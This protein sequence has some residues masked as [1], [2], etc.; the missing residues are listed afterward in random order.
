MNSESE[1]S[2]ESRIAAEVYGDGGGGFSA[3]VEL[4]GADLALAALEDRNLAI[5]VIE[6]ICGNLA[7]M[8]SRK[9][10]L[11]LAAHP[12][13]PRRIVLRLVREL[14]TF[15]LM[16]F[17]LLPAVAADL[18]RVAEELLVGRLSSV[19]LG[20]RVSLAR[21]SSARVAAALLLD[22]E[23]RVWQTALENPRLAESAVVAA[24]LRPGG[25]PAFVNAV[26]HHSKWSLRPEIRVA[27][28]R[29]EYTPLTRALEFARRLPPAV[30][31]DVLHSSRLPEKIKNY[32]RRDLENKGH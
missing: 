13:A 16:Q 27:L 24:L 29:N 31:R 5:E 9:V 18:K 14:Y 20:E 6:Q 10:R 25:S 3:A 17:S 12:R 32:L 1:N 26:C 11:A 19:S 23:A 30:L 2:G 15:D 28:L 21:R 7:V 8:K 22:R 4:P